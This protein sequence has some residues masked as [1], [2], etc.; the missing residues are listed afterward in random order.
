MQRFVLEVD[1]SEGSVFWH[2]RAGC[3]KMGAFHG[4]CPW[5][6]DFENFQRLRPWRLPECEGVEACSED[7]I[8]RNSAKDCR[9][10]SVLGESRTQNHMSAQCKL[11]GRSIVIRPIFDPL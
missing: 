11:F 10:E 1:G 2:G 4:L 3:G 5:M 8:L 9:G 7:D 6:V